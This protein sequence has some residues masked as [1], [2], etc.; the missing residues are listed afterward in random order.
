MT[1]KM[2]EVTRYGAISYFWL[3]DLSR[4]LKL[5]SKLQFP[6]KSDAKKRLSSSLVKD[7][8]QNRAPKQQFINCPNENYKV[9]NFIFS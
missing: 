3:R 2:P 8:P 1:G 7:T 6:K 9:T 4:N 5:S